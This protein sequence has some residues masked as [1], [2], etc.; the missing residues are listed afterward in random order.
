[1]ESAPPVFVRL[2]HGLVTLFAGVAGIAL[3]GML[4]LTVTNIG[5][6]LFGDPY[7]GTFELVSFLSIVVVGMSLA[8]AQRYKTHVAIDIV[9]SRWS[10][11]VQLWVGA[12]ITLFSAIIFLL[13]GQELIAYALNLQDKGSVSDSLRWP[14]W[15]LALTL[16]VGILALAL[17]LLADLVQIFHNLRSSQPESIW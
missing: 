8:L 1:M 2:V 17:A 11:R 9:V 6:R 12:A 16:S 7:A 3:I 14:Y 13:L 4:V 5:L 15:P 10:T